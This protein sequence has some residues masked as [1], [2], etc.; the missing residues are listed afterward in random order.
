MCIYERCSSPYAVYRTSKEWYTHMDIIHQERVWLCQV[1]QLKFRSDAHYREHLSDPRAHNLTGCLS[2][3]EI[4]MLVRANTVPNR[5]SK[6][7]F[8]DFETDG[9]EDIRP[10]IAVHLRQFALTSLPW[11][12]LI[13]PGSDEVSSSVLKGENSSVARMEDFVDGETL[14][15]VDSE[16]NQLPYDSTCSLALIKAWPTPCDDELKVQIKLWSSAVDCEG[17]D[18]LALTHPLGTQAGICVV[19]SLW[20]V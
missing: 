4:E 11:D 6:C 5:M 13:A 10:H 15:F 20:S 7:F 9:N 2:Q 16:E 8:C 14:D 3:D 12:V 1:C 19:V 17:R 18:V